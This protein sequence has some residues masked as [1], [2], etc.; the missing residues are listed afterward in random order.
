VVGFDDVPLTRDLHPPLTTVHLPLEEIGEHGMR[1]LLDERA[2]VAT[3]RVPAR[4]LERASSG[5][6]GGPRRRR[7]A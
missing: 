6:V 3:V 5:P 4:L 7:P 1:F 2:G